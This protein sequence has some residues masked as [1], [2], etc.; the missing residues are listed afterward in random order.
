MTELLQYARGQGFAVDMCGNKVVL[1]GTGLEFTRRTQEETV[2]VPPLPGDWMLIPSSGNLYALA[3]FV[4]VKCDLPQRYILAM[5]PAQE[6]VD[7]VTHTGIYSMADVIAL[8]QPSACIRLVGAPFYEEAFSAVAKVEQCDLEYHN[9]FDV[10]RD[11][12]KPLSEYPPS[13]KVTRAVNMIKREMRRRKLVKQAVRSLYKRV[14]IDVLREIAVAAELK[15]P[16]L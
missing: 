4:A 7:T 11:L 10:E 3:W 16:V 2:F 1:A 14:P 15:A 9:L 12:I 13:R 6:V 8:R 5:V